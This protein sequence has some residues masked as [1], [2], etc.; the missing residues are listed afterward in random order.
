MK[1]PS[2][3]LLIV[4]CMLGCLLSSTAGAQLSPRQIIQRAMDQMVFR[5][6]G[7]EMR[8][9]MTLRNRRNE[10]RTR[11]LYSRSLREGG[12]SRTLV[13]F[14][15]PSDV[16]GT[17]FLFVENQGKDDD[18]FMY[19][20]ALKATKRITGRQKDGRFMGSDFTFADLEWRDL[21]DASYKQLP[22]QKVGKYECHVIDAFP[23]NKSSL[24]H[25][26]RTWIRKSD[27]VLMRIRFFDKRSRL[28]KVMFV[29]E[30]KRV[31]G[32]LMVTRIKMTDRRKQHSTFMQI[33]QIKIRKDLKRD[34]FTVRA[35]NK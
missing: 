17:A 29:K 26:T 34:D 35:L 20:P 24:Y 16:A 15:S 25:R 22:M 8:I 5:S 30:V 4:T 2:L 6:Q 32:A 3:R 7:A 31:G 14:L 18:Q 12:L 10:T 28:I 13:R 23:N 11:T 33:S 19:L 21:D 1:T 9:V 27:S